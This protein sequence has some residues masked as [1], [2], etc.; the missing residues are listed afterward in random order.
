MRTGVVTDTFCLW[1]DTGQGH[2]ER[3]ARVP[4]VVKAI[5]DLPL[6][7]IDARQAECSEILRVHEQ[8][9]Y[10]SLCSTIGELFGK[11]TVANLD[12]DTTV[13]SQSWDAAIWAAGSALVLGEAWLEG[14]IDAGFACIRPPGHH[15]CPGRAM[16]FCLFNNIA[17]L[18][19]HLQEHGKRVAILDWDVHHGNGTQEIFQ[20]DPEVLF[21]SLHQWPL[22]P[23]TGAAEERGAGNIVNIPLPSGSGDEVYLRAF[24]EQALPALRDHGPD[25]VLVSAGFDAHARDPLAGMQLSDEA[26][27]IFTERLLAEVQ[28]PVLSVLE[29]G[30][31]LQAL[32]SGARAHVQA[33]VEAD[34]P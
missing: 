28:R 31:D 9:Y 27:G 19:R 30:Y 32:G 5:E 12:P 14:S 23:G 13:C 17:F 3:P 1:H 10:F 8:G 11:A 2:P 21:V 25:V 4:A 29:G 34:A 16:G 22:W 6:A 24:E 20:D 33:L 15:A 26:F 7:W 18:A